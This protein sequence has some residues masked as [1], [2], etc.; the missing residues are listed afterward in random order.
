MKV[1]LIT[2]NKQ[3]HW[4]FP[5]QK[6]LN[7]NLE[8]INPISEHKDPTLIL[9]EHDIIIFLTD[10]MK[11]TSMKQFLNKL[12]NYSI[13]YSTKIAF[14][15]EHDF[16]LIF[17]VFL[18]KSL[19][20]YFKR[21]YIDTLSF[22]DLYKFTLGY[23]RYRY[24]LN[25]ILTPIDM[26]KAY[27]SVKLKPLPTTYIEEDNFTPSDNKKYLVSFIS[28]IHEIPR[29]RTKLTYAPIY[30]NRV[31]IA[32]FLKSINNSYVRLGIGF[33]KGLPH[34]EYLRIISESLSSVSSYGVGYETIRYWE[35]P[36]AGSLLI[37][38]KPKI[39]IPNNLINGKHA[40][41]FKDIKELKKIIEFIK[42][43]PD[44]AIKMSKEARNFV[45]KYHSPLARAKYIINT[46]NAT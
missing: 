1:C 35:I 20:A 9:S 42:E 7:N 11:S 16:P 38:Q 21:E 39:K 37:A 44:I 3:T 24:N 40:F 15:D 28:N 22:N 5:F 18:H 26:I 30:K 33:M 34:R 23:L 4:K 32:K 10:T 14:I 17:R 31:I 41:F 8:I 27:R 45:I 13:S 2:S 6:L 36:Y 43:H 46:I 12:L 25:D 19:T 29:F